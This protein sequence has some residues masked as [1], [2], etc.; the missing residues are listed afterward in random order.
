MWLSARCGTPL[1]K[2]IVPQTA[3]IVP[4]FTEDACSLQS[5][6]QPTTGTFELRPACPEVPFIRCWS[7]HEIFAAPLSSQPSVICSHL[8]QHHKKVHKRRRVYR[9]NKTLIH[10]FSNVHG[11]YFSDYIHIL[12]L[13]SRRVRG[14]FRNVET[15]TL[16]VVKKTQK[17]RF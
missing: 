7:Y 16:C 11:G 13:I 12:C 17:T 14:L 5:S 1:H 8:R 9:I 6:Q 4:R 3:K 15:S 10:T 2:M